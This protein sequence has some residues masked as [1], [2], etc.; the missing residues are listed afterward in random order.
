MSARDPGPD[1]TTCV[2]SGV[3]STLTIRNSLAAYGPRSTHDGPPP[4]DGRDPELDG[5]I[6][7]AGFRI[8]GHFECRAIRNVIDDRVLRDRLLVE[9]EEREPTRV[10]TP[11]VTLELSAPVNL[12]L[13][14]PVEFSVQQFAG[15]IRRERLLAL[16]RDVDDVQVVASHERHQSPIRTEGRDLLLACFC[17][18]ASLPSPDE[19]E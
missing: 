10:G 11:P 2:E 18:S 9:L 14:E 4:V 5:R 16:R 8:V 12:F 17:S 6:G 15:S 3:Q 7:I 13:V 19:N 1:D